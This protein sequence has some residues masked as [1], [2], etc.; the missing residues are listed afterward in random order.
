MVFVTRWFYVRMVMPKMVGLY[1][2]CT[3]VRPR[4][5]YEAHILYALQ[6]NVVRAAAV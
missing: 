2:T 3:Y 5:V 4:K 6:M 1:L